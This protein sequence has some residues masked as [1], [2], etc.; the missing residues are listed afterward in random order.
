MPPRRRGT[1][2][3]PMRGRP[4]RLLPSPSHHSES[5]QHLNESHSSQSTRHSV[6]PH[7]S[8][9]HH[10]YHSR[11]HSHHD[12][13]NP[14]NYINLTHPSL[15]QLDNDSDPEMP[16]SGTNLHPIELSID[17]TTYAGSPYQGPDE[18]DQY[19]NQF[20]F[21]HT[22]EHKPQTPSYPPPQT[23]P[24]PPE[25]VQMELQQPPPQ[26]RMPRTGAQMSVR[27]VQCSGSLP[28]LP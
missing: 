5:S 23:L 11:S 2:K 16:P 6:S 8:Y 20:T 12:S 19:F 10:S 14:A 24:P 28:P 13:F 25:D 22:P 26:P 27:A 3:G 18:W 7:S 1:G 21:Y 15:N 17:T 4:S 9:S